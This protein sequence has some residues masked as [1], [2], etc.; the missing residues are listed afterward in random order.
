MTRND[1]H[2]PQIIVALLCLWEYQSI[3]LM[4]DNSIQHIAVYN[5]E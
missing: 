4:D 3:K 1:S 2:F 5:E